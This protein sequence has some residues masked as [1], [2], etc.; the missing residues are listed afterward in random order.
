MKE[1][2]KPSLF[3][4]QL[5]EHANHLISLI[6]EQVVSNHIEWYSFFL[7][8]YDKYDI[9]IIRLR[10]R[11]CI[12]TFFLVTKVLYPEFPFFPESWES[13]LDVSCLSN[14][15]RQEEGGIK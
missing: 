12:S 2:A 13:L 7:C 9:K 14:D 3:C 6:D 11:N 5:E 1:R 8:E 10:V 15:E 4:S